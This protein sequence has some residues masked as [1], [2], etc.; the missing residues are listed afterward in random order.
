MMIIDPV[1]AHLHYH[2]GIMPGVT[3]HMKEMFVTNQTYTVGPNWNQ[4]SR[5][6]W[7]SRLCG[8]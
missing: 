5:H 3:A 1:C 8:T 4:W 6:M 7:N 2:L